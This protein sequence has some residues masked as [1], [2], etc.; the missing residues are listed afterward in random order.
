[1]VII[2]K[3]YKKAFYRYCRQNQEE[4]ADEQKHDFFDLEHPEDE[5]KYSH[6]NNSPC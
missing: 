4:I 5:G 6:H 3:S 2:Q 1:V